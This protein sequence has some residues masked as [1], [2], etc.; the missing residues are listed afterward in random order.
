MGTREEG[1]RKMGAAEYFY[2]V[3]FETDI[4]NCDSIEPNPTV[5][6]REKKVYIFGTFVIA[7]H[8]ISHLRLL[9]TK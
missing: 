8:L 6:V 2:F 4:I 7:S 3:K 1:R 9:K 5:F